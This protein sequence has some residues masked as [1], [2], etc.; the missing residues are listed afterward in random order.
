VTPR[1]LL[2][3]WGAV[4][5]AVV[6]VFGYE[7][8]QWRALSA[9]GAAAAAERQRLTDDVRLRQQ[10]LAAEM[11]SDAGLLQGMQWSTA[12]VDSFV[13]LTH[14]AALA[15]EHR[16]KVMMVGPLER[17][18]TAQF[19]KSW[20][21]IQVVGPYHEVRELFGRVERARGIVEDVRIE[22][23]PASPAPRPD[24]APSPDEVQARFRLVALELSPEVKRMFDRRPAAG[25]SG[26][27]EQAPAVGGD[28]QES[29]T[30]RDPFAFGAGRRVAAVPKPPPPPPRP[31]APPAPLELSAI[32]GFPGGYVAIINNQIVKAG[33]VIGGV[34]IETIAENSVSVRQPD[35]PPRTI[36]LPE[37]GAQ[38]EAATR[39]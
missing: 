30:A 5:L 12:G 1:A 27:G 19:T 39:R 21:A 14:L 34:R 20:H 25:A 32:V 35:A 2:L 37:V 13:F 28:L 22:P 4:L 15:H 26:S 31:E 17:Q 9:Q 33:D 18:S 24:V 6:V 7:L 3:G 23:V 8:A 11:R 38:P 10:Q 16:L 36:M 29:A